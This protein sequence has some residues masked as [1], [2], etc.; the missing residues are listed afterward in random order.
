MQYQVELKELLDHKKGV[1]RWTET[2]IPDS[3][4]KYEG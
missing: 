2:E 1:L 3:S 4:P